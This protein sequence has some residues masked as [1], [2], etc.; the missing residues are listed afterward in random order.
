MAKKVSLSELT[1]AENNKKTAPAT[2]EVKTEKVGVIDTEQVKESVEA[3]TEKI[4]TRPSA[5]KKV[6]IADIKKELPVKEMTEEEIAKKNKTPEIVDNAFKDMVNT[7]EGKMKRFDEEFRPRIEEAARERAIEAELAESDV[8]NDENVDELPVTE[9]DELESMLSDYDVVDEESDNAVE[10]KEV[11]KISEK[12]NTQEDDEEPAKEEPKKVVKRKVA[13][14]GPSNNNL[15]SEID[16]IDSLLGDLEDIEEDDDSDVELEEEL[17]SESQEEIRERIKKQAIK[18]K[19]SSSKN[20][21]GFT[22][23]KQS[24]ASSSLLSRVKKKSNQRTADWPLL[25]SGKCCTFSE[26]S[27]PELEALERTIR[28]SNSVN[29]V[30]ASLKL[31]YNHIID[32]NKPSF[33]QWCKLTKYEDLESAYFG[34]YYATY[35][36]VNLIGRTCAKVKGKEDDHHC[37]KV[38]IIDTPVDTMYRIEDEEAK[39]KFDAL[40]QH[41]TTTQSNA[42]ETTIINISDTFAIGY[43]E[44]S[45][46]NTLIQFSSLPEKIVNKHQTMLNTM[47]YIDSFYY[48]DWENETYVPI[49]F[50]VYP[51]NLNKT[52]VSKL[53]VYVEICK[54]ISPDEYDTMVA[55]I[56][57][58]LDRES[59]IKYVLPETV[60]PECGETIPEE[61]TVS[62]LELLF[63]HRQLTALVN[64]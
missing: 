61:D 31:V 15:D 3:P 22:V 18:L 21:S 4:A 62:M 32:A 42:I 52:I 6:S 13:D 19:S 60:C 29:G 10:L 39:A 45:L 58:A 46:Y 36:E 8:N 55:K 12:I 43:T 51:D 47:A 28:T 26:T 9:D 24:V 57:S 14:K 34:L 11:V 1:A 53:K 27:G 20:T 64:S 63:T 54:L 25:A 40:M 48:I 59:K 37:G 7:M 41:D 5:M 49:T 30:I 50:K 33:E 35:G 2:K 38:S 23:S 16:S 56:T 17:E 44:P